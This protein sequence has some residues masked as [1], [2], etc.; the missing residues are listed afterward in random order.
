[1]TAPSTAPPLPAEAPADGAETAAAALHASETRYRRLFEAAQDGI[2]ILNASTGQIDDVNPYLLHLLGYA[3]GEMP[4]KK[5]WE[6]GAFADVE[7]CKAMF[8]ELQAE[9]YVR[10]HDLPLKTRGGTFVS[11]EF[12]SN[13]YLCDG[14]Q[15]M[16]C[17]IRDITASKQ[18][19]EALRASEKFAS[20]VAENMP[21]MLAYWN[22]ELRCR[23]A[24]GQY[25]KWFGRSEAQMIGI[26]I[27]DMQGESLFGQNEPFMRAALNG[28]TQQFERQLTKPDGQVGHTWVQYVPHQVDGEVQGFFA[29]AT[30]ITMLRDSQARQRVQAAS[31]K[32]VSQGV[33]I[34]GPDR[35][36]IS[37]NAAYKAISGYS[38]ADMLGRTCAFLQGP[39]TD[40]NV[41]ASIREALR[42]RTEF[43]GEILNYR[44]DGSTFWNELTI[45]PV[46]DAAGA[47]SH[48]VGVTRDIS[49]RK[50][51]EEALQRTNR[52]LQVI[53]RC[54][55][56]LAQTNGEPELLD[57]VCRAMVEAGGYVMAWVG[58][59]EN[60]AAKTVRP[61]AQ[62][63]DVSGYL[64]DFQ[65]SWDGSSPYGMGPSGSA[66]RH[67]STQ[68]NLDWHADPLM[69]PWRERALRSGFGSSI[70]VP[71]TGPTCCLGALAVYAAEPDAFDAEEVALL[72]ELARNLSF[73]IGAL[74]TRAQRDAA[75]AASA[76]KST[77]LANMS[78]EIRTP[79]N[80]I[81]GLNEL[82]LR[83]AATPQQA[84][85]L[86]KVASAGKHLLAIVND[87]LYLSK[88]EAVQV[89]LEISDFHLAAIFDQVAS[90]VG[91]AAHDKGLRL[92]VDIPAALP[93]LRGDAMRLRQALLNFAGNAVK[94]TRTG[95][96]TLRA[97]LMEETDGEL[98]VHCSVQ[99]SGIG[100]AAEHLPRLFQNFEQADTSTT[101]QYGGT[102][103]GLAITRRLALLMGGDAGAE[104]TPGVGSTF[105]F[106]ARLRRGV[107]AEPGVGGTASVSAPVAPANATESTGVQQ[108]LSQRHGQARILVVE[109]NEVNLEL[110]L[111]WLGNAGLS[112]DTASDG[113]EAVQ[114]AQETAYDLILMDMQ[115]PVMDGL[116]ATR[117]IRALPGRAAVPILA[118]TANAFNEERDVCLAAGMN[119]FVI[120]PVNVGALYV[121]LLKWLQPSLH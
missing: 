28:A 106:T 37:A 25:Q 8:A 44:K 90:I 70:A 42:N 68:I 5:L 50:R 84:E 18:A 43:A 73:G 71:L 83:D 3:H 58:L 75:E 97:R 98:L 72:E 69:A 56:A 110:A 80:A 52:T 60:D 104:S 113:R 53:S 20:A 24:N 100:I 55:L 30:D 79:L 33:L 105:W 54:N 61:V 76:S 4:G 95:S 94:F 121:T 65:C 40:L 45:S 117:A 103:L 96:V 111:A 57:A 27:Q 6:V 85:R 101:R 26:R 35:L 109:D 77:F 67:A 99:D 92:E 120:K 31:L 17:N 10:Y 93:W 107:A 63:G 86:G 15:V 38:E 21:G 34:A 49:E 1:M 47:L 39:G 74:R 19:E 36:I 46:F 9:G 23:F 87:I 14:V 78:H 88:I 116:E 62:A 66:I 102:G 119:D 112:A 7:R 22:R 13:S 82:L 29:L 89:Q 114:R 91:G 41:V 2:L 64:Q 118:M 81:I 11:V 59:A 32:A 16:Q 108:Q 48:Y 12:V 115:M 51:A